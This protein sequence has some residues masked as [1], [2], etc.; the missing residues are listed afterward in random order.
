M[1][2]ESLFA[3]LPSAVRELVVQSASGSQVGESEADK[4]EVSGWIAKASD[5]GFASPST[6]PVESSTYSKF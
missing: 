4:K 3:N 2:T 5:T 6:L 1:S